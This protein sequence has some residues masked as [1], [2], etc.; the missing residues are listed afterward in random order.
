MEKTEKIGILE[1]Y[2][3]RTRKIDEK[4]KKEQLDTTP[5]RSN[6]LKESVKTKKDNI[7]DQLN[8]LIREKNKK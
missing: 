8:K 2:N 4:R 5:N 1:W 6:F 7:F 3:E